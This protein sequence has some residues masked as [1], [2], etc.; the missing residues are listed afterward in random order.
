MILPLQ[1]VER[2]TQGAQPQKSAPCL[3]CRLGFLSLSGQD[4][5]VGGP[6][7]GAPRLLRGVADLTL[8]IWPESGGSRVS[9]YTWGQP[10]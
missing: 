4:Q 10:E 5:G 2:Q 3:S 1:D 9:G 8:E 6:L 7:R